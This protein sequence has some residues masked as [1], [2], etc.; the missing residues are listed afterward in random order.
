[1]RVEAKTFDI[2]DISSGELY[3]IARSFYDEA[4]KD[5]DGGYKS[6]ALQEFERAK[7]LFEAYGEDYFAGRCQE[8]IDEIN[9][10]NE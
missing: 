2:T 7:M 9:E 6:L 5:R 10:E 3:F 8:E 4:K 1:M